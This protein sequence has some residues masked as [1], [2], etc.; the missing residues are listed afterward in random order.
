[1]SLYNML[2]GFNP[3]CFLFM[4]ML[5]KKQEE[6]PRFRDCFLSDDCK[7]IVIYTR[8]G[9]G[10]REYY[11][12]ENQ[13]MFND[14]LYVKDYDEEDDNTYLY[15]EFNVPEKWV[16]DFNL[17]I[18]GK[19]KETSNDYKELIHSFYP[20]IYNEIFGDSSNESE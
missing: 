5:G 20:K 18:K 12:E 6:Y 9:G 10:N 8:T 16:E 2:F 11:E 3:S 7:R 17:I 19:L 14:P 15:V 13:I 1:M 4:P